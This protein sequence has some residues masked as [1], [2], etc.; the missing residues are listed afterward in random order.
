LSGAGDPAIHAAVHA[1]CFAAAALVLIAGALAVPGAPAWAQCRV[2][3]P[4][5]RGETG[6]S[7][8]EAKVLP[9][10]VTEPLYWHLDRYPSLAAARAAA[11]PASVA[12]DAHGTAWLMTVEPQGAGHR[13]GEHVAEIGPLPLPEAQSAAAPRYAM[14]VMSALFD[15]GVVS[16]IHAHP[17]PEAFY[18]IE[19]E[20]CLET[21]Q[22]AQRSRAGESHIVAGD[23]Q[24]RVA[25]TGSGR[26]RA[27][28][29]ILHDASQPAIRDLDVP[30]QTLAK[31]E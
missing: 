14:Q 7:I 1:P 24:M 8:L 22:G 12:A 26:R 11:G 27:L 3:S 16:A 10:L 6:C 4:E 13:G 2:D 17:G 28:V 5:R 30:P 29:L 21:N 23:V 20:Q 18:V 25:A 9:G 31:C 19:G 15:P